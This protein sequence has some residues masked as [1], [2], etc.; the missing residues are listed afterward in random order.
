MKLLQ[1]VVAA[2]LSATSALHL[3]QHKTNS[4]YHHYYRQ[5]L[6]MKLILIFIIFATNLVAQGDFV[7]TYY[8]QEG[9]EYTFA[10]NSKQ[11]FLHASE[12]GLPPLIWQIRQ[13]A[14]SD[15]GGLAVA[16]S[17][18]T[19]PAENYTFVWSLLKVQMTSDYGTNL[20]SAIPP[21][22]KFCFPVTGIIDRNEH[23]LLY[24]DHYVKYSPGGAPHISCWVQYVRCTADGTVY[25]VDLDGEVILSINERGFAHE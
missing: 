13:A 12:A 19:T 23:V 1:E 2:L 5:I 15:Y 3:L 14:K 25:A 6:H 11:I 10:A 18:S 22:E 7:Q 24:E 16:V 17:T 21:Q 8:D 4:F 9:R 20:L